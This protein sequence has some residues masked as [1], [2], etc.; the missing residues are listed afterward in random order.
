MDFN[1]IERCLV[2]DLDSRY[3]LILGMAWIKRHEPWIDWR[4]KTSGATRNVPSEVLESYEPTFARQQ[5]HYWRE[6]L[7]ENVNVL[8]IGMSELNSNVKNTNFG[9]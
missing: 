5:K 3:D 7:I 8:D 6:P 1:S 4:S 2:L 9:A